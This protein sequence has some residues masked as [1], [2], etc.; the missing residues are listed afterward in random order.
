[1]GRTSVT[2]TNKRGDGHAT[3]RTKRLSQA[4]ELPISAEQR[5]VRG[6]LG[7]LW[8]ALLVVLVLL[9]LGRRWGWHVGSCKGRRRRRFVRWSSS[10]GA[11]AT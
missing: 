7:L 6:T 3:P 4:R 10:V 9:L 1:M 2:T 5:S 8:M 11:R